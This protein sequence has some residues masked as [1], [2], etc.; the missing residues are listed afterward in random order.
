[1]NNCEIKKGDYVQIRK[2][3]QYNHNFTYKPFLVDRVM[4]GIVY[5]IHRHRGFSCHRL[6][7]IL[8]PVLN[9]RIKELRDFK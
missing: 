2:E 5:E 3:E 8:G 9:D 4:N 1:M 6:E 7:K